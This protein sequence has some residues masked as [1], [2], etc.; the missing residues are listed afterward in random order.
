[1]ATAEAFDGACLVRREDR[2]LASLA[3]GDP[4]HDSLGLHAATLL[5]IS[6]EA[7]APTFA[8]DSIL[9]AILEKRATIWLARVDQVAAAAQGGTVLPGLDRCLEVVVM[10]LA[11]AAGL[12]AAIHAAESFREAYGIEPVT[13]FAPPEAGGLVAMNS[14]PNRATAAHEVTLNRGS[15]GRVI[16]GVVVWPTVAERTRT[17][18]PRHGSFPSGDAGRS[19]AIGATF[20]GAVGT[21]LAA[22]LLADAFDVDGDGF[23]VPREG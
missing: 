2:L 9:A 18:R 19:L 17:G 1:M 4:L 12:P 21:A 14:P 8:V 11:S 10:P 7:V 23:L 16:N 22:V 3:P 13:A 15:V 6:A 20:P 5:G